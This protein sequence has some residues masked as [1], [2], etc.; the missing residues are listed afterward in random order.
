LPLTNKGGTSGFTVEGKPPRPGFINDACNRVISPGYLE[1]MRIAITR[2]RPFEERDGLTSPPV[3]IINQTMGR[4]FWPDMDPIGKRFK[5][6]DPGDKTPW[7]TIVGVSRDVRQ[8]GLDQPVKAEMSFHYWQAK[9]NWMVPQDL[10]LRTNSDPMRLA[11][12]VRQAIW[13]IDRN[14]PVSDVQTLDDLLDHEVA[15]RRVQATLLGAL[16]A[17]ALVLACV[18]IYGVLSYLVT[19]RTQEI[20]VRLALGADGWDIL[21]CVARHGMVLTG[22]GIVV[23]TAGALALSRLVSGMLYGVSAN[24][25]VVY[26]GASLIFGLVALAACLI[27]ASRAA[28]IDPIS[29]L[30]YE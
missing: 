3:A 10:V 22:V 28:R 18:G 17:L 11:G 30:R 15:Q 27:P 26:C 20:G 2:G 6:G 29:A 8:M 1:T 13:S 21:R 24:D 19:R 23:G 16:A 7:F 25:P 12:S 5:F 14:Q 9:D 4:Q